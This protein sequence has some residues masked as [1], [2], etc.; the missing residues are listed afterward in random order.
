MSGIGFTPT[1]VTHASGG[2][3]GASLLRYGPSSTASAAE[4]FGDTV[5]AH[6]RARR[7]L[8]AARRTRDPD[9]ANNLLASHDRQRPLCRGDL[10]E[11]QRASPGG[12]GCHTLAEFARGR[13]ERQGGVCLA[14]A[15][16]DSVR[17]RAVVMQHH[18]S[19]AGA[20]HYSHRHLIPV[21][22]AL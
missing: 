12:R 16:L 1:L 2:T 13:A 5:D 6:L 9:S 19:T 15:V 21:L 11:V 4:S 10:I 14:Q 18:R 20:V 22:T 17:I 8:V 7:V 3:A